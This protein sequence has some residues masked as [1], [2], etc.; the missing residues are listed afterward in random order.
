MKK[1]ELDA[2]IEAGALDET[3]QAMREI[4]KVGH[5]IGLSKP[6]LAMMLRAI[7]DELLP[8]IIVPNPET[9]H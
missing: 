5:N 6:A 9:Q 4:V 3:E 8:P 2:A 1:H 7:A